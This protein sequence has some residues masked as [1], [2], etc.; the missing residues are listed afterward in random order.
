MNFLDILITSPQYVIRKVWG[1]DRRTCSLILGVKWLI[2]S[3][4]GAS[5]SLGRVPS[6]GKTSRVTSTPLSTMPIST[7]PPMTVEEDHKSVSGTSDKLFTMPLFTP[8]KG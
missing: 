4:V 1:Q 3:M 5:T 7:R 6:F 2:L 8:T